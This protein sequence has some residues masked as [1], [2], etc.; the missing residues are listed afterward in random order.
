[1]TEDDKQLIYKFVDDGLIELNKSGMMKKSGNFPREMQDESFD[2]KQEYNKW[3]AV[4]STVTNADITE[5]EVIVNCELPISFQT[6]LKY[7]HFYELWLP[8]VMEVGF[9]S[10]PIYS[11]K[12]NYRNFYS[13]DWVQEELIEN[14]F[15]P[16][17]NHEDWGY[18][19]F[20]ARKSY[21]ENEY[22]ILMIDHEL[23]GDPD[24]YEKFNNN[25]MDM[26]RNRLLYENEK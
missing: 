1:M 17:A 23:I 25:F 3:K 20:D 11:W 4:K 6:F 19:C 26:V 21:T 15:I 10:H 16:F 14:K 9:F 7:K 8:G 18:L 13:Y 12:K 2:R 5:L 22:P 24:K